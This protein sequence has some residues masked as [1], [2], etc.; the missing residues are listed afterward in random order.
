[1]SDAVGVGINHSMRS[2]GT[3][4]QN[5]EKHRI[6]SHLINHGPTSKGVSEVIEQ[7]SEQSERVR[8]RVSAVERASKASSAEQANE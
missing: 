5:R 1:M 8:E 7:R 2:H 3:M 4:G 6:N